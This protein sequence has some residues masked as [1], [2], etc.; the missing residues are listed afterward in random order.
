MSTP[1]L[2]TARGG[3]SDDERAAVLALVR[4][5]GWNATS[6]Q[7]LEP[8]YRY[9]FVGNDA[10]VAYVDT[11]K[12]WVAAGA[13]LAHD[14][15][16]VVVTAAFVAAARAAGRRACLFATEE[17]FTSLVALPSVPVGEQ[18]VW[19]PASWPATLARSRHLREQLRRARAKGV[20]VRAVPVQEA[21]A[22][23]TSIR[24]AV[25]ELVGRWLQSRELAPMGF[26]VQAEPFTLLPGHH[27]FLAERDHQVI[28]LLS[29]APIYARNGW[30]FQ[31]LVRAPNA[32][33]GTTETLVDRAMRFASR[34]GAALVTLGLAPLAGDVPRPLRFARR[35]GRALFDFEGLRSFKA[36]LHPARWDRVF[37]TFPP[38]VTAAR[39]LGD[40]LTA[41]ARGGL[42]RFGLR[43]LL[44]GPTIV[45][46]LLAV[47]LVPWTILLASA[48]SQ[49]WFPDPIVKW[50]WVAFD[51]CLAIG[52]YSLQRRWRISLARALTAA[53][54]TD[55]GLTVIEAFAWNASRAKGGARAVVALAV[56]A[57]LVALAA[58]WRAAARR[59]GT[60]PLREL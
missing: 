3:P 32:P 53:V 57:P 52:L 18:P 4:R 59:R 36:K 11:G 21:M 51:V 31:H 43:T 42:L 44:R 27:L 30:L 37:L 26:L 9:F 17:R 34:D 7:V 35:A 25:S 10:C 33:N 45:V 23:D 29:I 1:E 5:H 16:M 20:C 15:R 46:R 2:W 6:F 28:A 12:A 56:A 8:G 38:D 55:V 24:A 39:A 54:A 47:F 48:D 50:A 13:P 58:L 41:F 22:A 19:D 40:A 14:G 49:I 60:S